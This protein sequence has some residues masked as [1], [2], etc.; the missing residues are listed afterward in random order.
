MDKIKALFKFAK[1][2]NDAVIV[3]TTSNNHPNYAHLSPFVLPAPPAKRFE[4]LWQFSKVYPSQVYASGEPNDEWVTWREQGWNDLK[5]HRY[6]MGK[7]AIP[8]YSHWQ[9]KHL[10][11]IEARKQIY[12]PE[13]AKNVIKTRAYKLLELQY[14]ECCQSNQ[15]L[16]LL[17]YDAY[18]HFSLGM[19]LIDV[20]NNPKR[21]MG[22]A[23]VLIMMLIDV[24]EECVNS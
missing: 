8:L 15:E 11:Y 10:N 9:G 16:I 18:D 2:S 3:D 13:Y 7:G 6:P 4:N 19:S 12:A 23:F 17:D 5:A 22:H 21:K 14:K 20:I 24:L 1:M